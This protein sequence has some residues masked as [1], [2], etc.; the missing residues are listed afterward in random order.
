MYNFDLE[1]MWYGQHYNI[2][3]GYW[4]WDVAHLLIGILPFYGPGNWFLPVVF[5]SILLM[6][7]LYKGFS[8]KLK[9]SIVSLCLCYIVELGITSLFRFIVPLHVSSNLEWRFY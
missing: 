9:W 4:R 5:W 6:P 7:L 2:V 1:A 8:G 3:F